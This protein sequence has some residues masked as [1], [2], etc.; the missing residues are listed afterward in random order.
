MEWGAR[1]PPSAQVV[2]L[3]RIAFR[4]GAM[5]WNTA[6]RRRPTLTLAFADYDRGQPGGRT[7]S[8]AAVLDRGIR[9]SRADPLLPPTCHLLLMWADTSLYPSG[10]LG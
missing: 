10:T 2:C 1:P 7:H 9:G 8:R 4:S 6:E 3:Q 5:L